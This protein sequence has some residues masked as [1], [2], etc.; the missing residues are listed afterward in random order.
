MYMYATKMSL[1]IFR[2]IA[3]EELLVLC[4]FSCNLS[5]IKQVCKMSKILNYLND[6]FKSC[7]RTVEYLDNP[8]KT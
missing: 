5:S 8:R 7:D 3:D 6:C 2:K 1:I 4:Q